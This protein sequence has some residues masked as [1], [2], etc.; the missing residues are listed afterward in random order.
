MIMEER[1]IFYGKAISFSVFVISV[2]LIRCLI[3]QRSTFYALI[4][5]KNL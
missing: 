3:G 2:K 5:K 1:K 4:V